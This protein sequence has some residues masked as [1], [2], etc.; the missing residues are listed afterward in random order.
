MIFMMNEELKDI[1][2]Q[3]L[4]LNDYERLKQAK[5]ALANVLAGLKEINPFDENKNLH[6]MLVI[7]RSLIL[8]DNMV[9][10]E[11]VVLFNDLFNSCFSKEEIEGEFLNVH[12]VEYK[13]MEQTIAKLNDAARYDLFLLSLLFLTSDNKL[14]EEELKRLEEILA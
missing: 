10:K 4:S 5:L 6:Y 2:E 11:E 12:P 7:S 14:T 3:Y 9:T 1:Y 8:V 13:L